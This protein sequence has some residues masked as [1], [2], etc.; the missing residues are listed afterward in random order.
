[1]PDN[2]KQKLFPLAFHE[3]ENNLPAIEFVFFIDVINKAL[4]FG[5]FLGA[6]CNFL[7]FLVQVHFTIMSVI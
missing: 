6:H 3:I 4:E 1:M 2:K 5:F 7:Q